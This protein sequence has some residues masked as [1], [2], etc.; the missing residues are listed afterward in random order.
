M[1]EKN[2]LPEITI[3]KTEKYHVVIN[4]QGEYE[5]V[6]AFGKVIINLGKKV[7]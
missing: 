1:K 6:N 5:I 2:L 7:A 3:L 4:T